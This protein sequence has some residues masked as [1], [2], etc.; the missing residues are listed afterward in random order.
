MKLKHAELGNLKDIADC[1][2]KLMNQEIEK[3]GYSDLTFIM[4]GSAR[5][6][7]DIITLNN[8]ED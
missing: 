4:E 1:L 5:G 6:I 3:N 8:I 2:W 7:Y